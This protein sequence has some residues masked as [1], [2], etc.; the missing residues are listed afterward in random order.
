MSQESNVF[1]KLS[2]EMNMTPM[3][4]ETRSEHERPCGHCRACGC[5]QPR[6]TS[7][8]REKKEGEGD[9]GKKDILQ[10]DCHKNI[11]SLSLKNGCGMKLV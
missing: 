1:K 3:C 6:V 2:R 4:L 5:Q 10:I 9:K 7:H 8:H 11:V